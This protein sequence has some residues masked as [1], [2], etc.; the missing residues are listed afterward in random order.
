MEEGES[1]DDGAR[2]RQRGAT[3]GS[4]WLSKRTGGWL[5]WRSGRRIRWRRW[6]G[7]VTAALVDSVGAGGGDGI[8]SG[9]RCQYVGGNRGGVGREKNKGRKVMMEI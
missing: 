8:G 2:W 3:I 6:G 9:A 7:W 5:R 1:G 4:Q